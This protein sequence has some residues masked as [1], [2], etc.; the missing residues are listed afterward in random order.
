MP[1]WK[2]CEREVSEVNWQEIVNT[3]DL[4]AEVREFIAGRVAERVG[5]ENRFDFEGTRRDCD[6]PTPHVPHV[7][8][9]Y[10]TVRYGRLQRWCLGREGEIPG[11]GRLNIVVRDYEPGAPEY[12]GSA[13]G[14]WFVTGP[15]AL[16]E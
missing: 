10:D 14:W 7:V 4:Q 5:E 6:C 2:R 13:T 11:Q 3:F 16:T 9:C 1:T 15:D 8:G 12:P